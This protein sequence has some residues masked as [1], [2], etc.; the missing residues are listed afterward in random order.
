MKFLSIY[1]ILLLIFCLSYQFFNKDYKFKVGQCVYTTIGK[2]K[3]FKKIKRISW[4]NYYYSI[5]FKNEYLFTYNM[6][7]PP[8]E[9]LHT[10]TL[11]K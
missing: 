6:R 4:G 2:E 11:C 5:K 10:L 9:A 8:F 3:I 7:K 1:F